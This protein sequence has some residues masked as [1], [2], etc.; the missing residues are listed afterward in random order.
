MLRHVY[1]TYGNDIALGIYGAS[2][3]EVSNALNTFYNYH[4]TDGEPH[5]LSDTFGYILTTWAQLEKA[6]AD[7]E[8]AKILEKHLN[9]PN[10]VKRGLQAVARQSAKTFVTELPF[11][12]F[13]N[14]G[15]PPAHVYTHHTSQRT[16]PAN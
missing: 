12:N 5:F 7:M 13:V 4:A 9:A 2:H 8:T 6:V 3:D 11:D 10:N 15:S 14:Q 16:E 1:S